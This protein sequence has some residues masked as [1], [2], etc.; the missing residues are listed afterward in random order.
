MELNALASATIQ[1][2]ATLRAR[3]VQDA[4]ELT[5]YTTPAPSLTLATTNVST[6]RGSTQHTANRVK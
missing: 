5:T 6:V 4:Q 2:T 3:D 1:A